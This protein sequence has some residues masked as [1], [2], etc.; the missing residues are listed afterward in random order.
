[1]KVVWKGSLT[2]G[3]VNIPIKLYAA[4]Q[5]HALG[6]T[7]LHVRC[8]TP[9]NYHRW[10]P[11]C[12]KEVSWDQTVKGIKKENGSYIVLTKE[13]LACLHPEKT[14]TVA[15]V[16]CIDAE[17][18]NPLYVSHHYY[19]VPGSTSSHAYILFVKALAQLGKVAIGR[20]V[21]HD[22]EY[23]CALRPFEHYLLLTTLHY[24]Y[25]IKDIKSIAPNLKKMAVQPNEL[26][27]AEKLIASLS[28]DTFNVA[29]FKDTF[30]EKIKKKLRAEK[31]GKKTKK[32]K[33]I[34]RVAEK[35]KSS[36]TQALH[37]SLEQAHK[38]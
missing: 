25:E 22:K 10:C 7:L 18:L 5:E 24:S 23:T 12:D 35:K 36:L 13:T 38:R 28:T 2:F 26:K 16:S 37:A 20:F 32:S 9:L 3:L 8:H 30:A 15:I 1:M 33:H 4:T 21:M 11:K 31:T 29:Q 17:K 19:A 34:K 6:F 14:D 27:L